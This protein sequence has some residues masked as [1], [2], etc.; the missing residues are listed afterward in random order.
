MTKTRIQKLKWAVVALFI[1]FCAVALGFSTAFRNSMPAYAASGQSFLNRPQN[2]WSSVNKG[3]IF[4]GSDSDSYV[5]TD[6]GESWYNFTKCDNE[7]SCWNDGTL[8]NSSNSTSYAAATG[9]YL[10]MNSYASAPSGNI[11][12]ASALNFQW[13]TNSDLNF[14]STYPYGVQYNKNGTQHWNY[15]L[16][17]VPIQLG[18]DA[19]K[20]I[21]SGAISS[22]G[23][24]V[25][26]S[27]LHTDAWQTIVRMNAFMAFASPNQGKSI[28]SKLT[29]W[30]SKYQTNQYAYGHNGTANTTVSVSFDMTLD[31]G[32]YPSTEPDI[33][34][35]GVFVSVQFSHGASFGAT[36]RI[37]ITGLEIDNF[38]V[39]PSNKGL[40]SNAHNPSSPDG[41]WS[42]GAKANFKMDSG[43]WQAGSS[44]SAKTLSTSVQSLRVDT[45]TITDNSTVTAPDG[46]F[47]MGYALNFVPGAPIFVYRK[48]MLISTD[49]YADMNINDFR[50]CDPSNIWFDVAYGSVSLSA[51]ST[52]KYTGREIV[53]TVN[54]NTT[55]K[56]NTFQFKS[57]YFR[58]DIE[59]KNRDTGATLSGAPIEVGK[60][61][62]QV[63]VY[64]TSD[65][66]NEGMI[67]WGKIYNNNLKHFKGENDTSVAL[68]KSTWCNFEITKRDVSV[69]VTENDFIFTGGDLKPL[70]S[71]TEDKSKNNSSDP[72]PDLADATVTGNGAQR[73]VTED[74]NG[75]YWYTLTL[76]STSYYK[77]ASYNTADVITDD[78]NTLRIRFR[79]KRYYLDWNVSGGGNST[80]N[81]ATQNAPFSVD[82][83]PKIS[84]TDVSVDS[85]GDL[86]AKN[87]GSYTANYTLTGED[88]DNYT[89]SAGAAAPT[90]ANVDTVSKNWQIVPASITVVPELRLTYNAAAQTPAFTSAGWQGADSQNVLLNTDALQAKTDHA[91]GGY[92]VTFTLESGKNYIFDNHTYSYTFTW[93]I[94]K[95]PLTFTAKSFSNTYGDPVPELQ[96]GTTGWNH[97]N[98]YTVEGYK[99]ADNG[100]GFNSIIRLVYQAGVGRYSD[101]GAYDVTVSEDESQITDAAN[102]EKV[103]RNYNIAFIDGVYT[104]TPRTVSYTVDGQTVD[105]GNPVALTGSSSDAVLNRDLTENNVTIALFHN[106]GTSTGG[107]LKAGDHYQ[108]TATLGG[109]GAGNY[110]FVAA[111]AALKINKITVK[112]ALH[113]FSVTYGDTI[114]FVGQWEKLEGDFLP[115][116][117]AEVLP[118]LSRQSNKPTATGHDA[119][120]DFSGDDAANYNAEGVYDLQGGL[121]KNYAIVTVNKRTV[122]YRFNSDDG[123]ITG[124]YGETYRMVGGAWTANGTT[125]TGY[126]ADGYAMAYDDDVSLITDYLKLNHSAIGGC[127]FSASASGHLAVGTYTLAVELVASSEANQNYNVLFDGVRL[128]VT[129][130][131]ITVHIGDMSMA[132]GDFYPKN[133]D[134]ALDGTLAEGDRLKDLWDFAIVDGEGNKI[135]T[136]MKETERFGREEFITATPGDYAIRTVK[137]TNDLANNYIIDAGTMTQTFTVTKRSVAISIGS[138]GGSFGT[139][140][141]TE[142]GVNRALA[143]CINVIDPMD[144]VFPEFEAG[145]MPF[146]VDS[147][148]LTG[149]TIYEWGGNKY[150]A[151]GSYSLPIN[152]SDEYKDKYQIKDNTAGALQ[153]GKGTYNMDGV[154]FEDGTFEYDGDP[155]R[156]QIKGTLPTGVDGITVGIS[157]S[158]FPV[159]HVSDGITTVTATF[160]T[161][162]TNYSV[163][164]QRTAQ[165]Q[166]SPRSIAVKANDQK[167]EYCGNESNLRFN[168]Y[169]Y[170]VTSGTLVAGDSLGLVLVK[171]AGWECG[172]YPISFTDDNGNPDYEIT[173]KNGTFTVEPRN[174]ENASIQVSGIDPD[175]YTYTG[176]AVNLTGVAIADR[177]VAGIQGLSSGKDYF[178]S[179]LDNTNVVRDPDGNIQ[180]AAQF[181]VS[182]I[183]NYR[184]SFAV[185][186]KIIPKEISRDIF[187]GSIPTMTYNGNPQTPGSFEVKDT[188]RNAK[189]SAA[190]DYSVS[191]ENITDA[192]EAAQV[193]LTGKGNYTG[194]YTVYY[195]I[196]PCHVGSL[197]IAPIAEQEYNRNQ[198]FP[199]PTVTL[200]SVALTVDR[201]FTFSYGANTNVGEGSVTVTGRGNFTGS[202]EVNFNI[203]PKGLLVDQSNVKD[204]VYSGNPRD[205]SV[206]FEG[207]IQGDPA[208]KARVTYYTELRV[209]L[210]GTPVDVGSYIASVQLEDGVINYTIQKTEVEFKITPYEVKANWTIPKS[211]I[212]NGTFRTV[213]C[214]ANMG[215]TDIKIKADIAIV[216]YDSNGGV[217]DAP[218]NAGVYRAVAELDPRSATSKNF[219]LKENDEEFPTAQELRIEKATLNVTPGLYKKSFGDADGIYTANVHGLGDDGELQVAFSRSVSFSKNDWDPEN[220]LDWRDYEQTSATPYL[221]D[222]VEFT[223]VNC[224]NNYTLVLLQGEGSGLRIDA[225]VIDKVAP[226]WE[227]F[228]G[229]ADP[230]F[231]EEWD[232]GY[233]GIKAKITYTRATGND[234]GSYS[235]LSFQLTEDSDFRN[236]RDYAN[237]IVNFAR[238]GARNKF[239]I[240]PV[241]I[242]Y[243]IK[244]VTKTFGQ[245]DD[246]SKYEWEQIVEEGVETPSLTVTVHRD[247]GESAI[248]TGYLI[249]LALSNPNYVAKINRSEPG[250]GGRL[251]VEPLRIETEDNIETERLY[252]GTDI[253]TASSD[254]NNIPEA[255]RVSANF[256]VIAT[257]SQSS[258][259]EGIDISVRYE[260]NDRVS[261]N[262][263]L[264]EARVLVGEG[265]IMPRTIKVWIDD[266][267]MEYGEEIPEISLRYDNLIAGDRSDSVISR[268]PSPAFGE[269][270]VNANVGTY[271]IT[272]NNDGQSTNYIFDVTDTATVTVKRAPISVTVNEE[273]GTFVQTVNGD[274]NVELDTDWFLFDGLKHGDGAPVLYK[275]AFDSV[276]PGN[277]VIIVEFSERE[278]G[279]Y[280]LMNRFVSVPAYLKPLPVITFDNVRTVYNGEAVGVNPS[281]TVIQPATGTILTVGYAVRYVGDNYDSREA[282]VGAGTYTVYV[283]SADGYY[284]TVRAEGSLQI[285][286]AAVRIII[287]GNMKQTYGEFAELS[288]VA[289]GTDK[290]FKLTVKYPF[291][292]AERPEAGTHTVEAVFDGDANYLPNAATAELKIEPRALRVNF[293]DFSNLVYNGQPQ[294]ITATFTGV[295]EGDTCEP[296]IIYSSGTVPKDA[297]TY[298][299]TVT[300]SD[301]SY[302]VSGNMMQ[303]YTIQKRQLTITANGGTVNAGEKPDTTLIFD[304][305]VQGEGVGDIKDLPNVS[306][307]GVTV[308]EN[309]IHL[310][311]GDDENYD[312][313]LESGTFTVVYEKTTADKSSGTVIWI[314][315][316]CVLG[317]ALLITIIALIARRKQEN[318]YTKERSRRI[319]W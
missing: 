136:V 260:V 89:F 79:I 114:S 137:S 66:E 230:D 187:V 283:E 212:Y 142:A 236:E 156:P 100:L 243:K 267:T 38:K 285:D 81:G 257:F 185:N 78:E 146:A 112:V 90:E 272:L 254:R 29:D 47:F 269:F 99:G 62:A 134:A 179:Y 107:Y 278:N 77:F 87:V 261:A 287:G 52:Y 227:K 183:G 128:T 138:L 178:V 167:S 153:I 271:V 176:K 206:T 149:V 233:F 231:I 12:T 313:V 32:G 308:G 139:E 301:S 302:T 175:G 199:T 42:D 294:P 242:E 8:R 28:T 36:R 247:E 229:Q 319:G 164:A 244:D 195:T 239:T 60:Y 270:G 9:K 37:E 141:A 307:S 97:R 118:H 155:H 53:P 132:Y 123:V 310:S 170:S 190:D 11:S 191:Y 314:V 181:I 145:E 163:P 293:S 305:F 54:L 196:L 50:M 160:M 5:N 110:N 39:N 65:K 237:F 56:N 48:E 85:S 15:F 226:T 173:K 94:D 133:L 232:S 151:V 219:T 44:A 315:L 281:V 135:A 296:I 106:A 280:Y 16:Y 158:G 21:R 312:F 120:V 125:L 108:I 63:T 46:Y 115:G 103:H 311:G 116:D 274:K 91:D 126:L 255:Y 221:F 59:Y 265:K 127:G 186:F 35:V 70:Y 93:F 3:N 1:G 161:A 204:I 148:N 263:I 124:V 49:S 51:S 290:E 228:Y 19:R 249:N 73:N 275:A 246:T 168:A 92:E 297:G 129:P 289:R 222:T 198:I 4:G 279:N 27:N 200:N 264:P 286:K 268:E 235:F 102:I 207:V 68:G 64:Y 252:N 259:G 180:S 75:Y 76:T 266:F 143:T 150:F 30:D 251:Y 101:V 306:I 253:V 57:S 154:T 208:P 317:V 113:D 61:Q 234:V 67:T 220:P 318:E 284:D 84:G 224:D 203:V 211:M 194:T 104:V 71:K 223:S 182:G 273:K 72:T 7:G 171:T 117:D 69:T 201:D 74:N 23:A 166:I 210:D 174:I 159:T 304:G 24:R 33:L 45:D 40:Y 215:L 214:D 20:Q 130:R 169:D 98:G 131:P 193:I 192:S 316:S 291:G 109:D 245:E 277:T 217:I 205:L 218:R 282:P 10:T 162:S 256:R 43:G 288:A 241:H 140:G 165:A 26:F 202:R 86:S 152:V 300:P 122:A 18:S 13:A 189:L 6:D 184:G 83:L 111:P 17:Y 238:D 309:S 2:G 295:L 172:T 157:Y 225:R 96:G 213:R 292:T 188:G 197:V 31:S 216:Y 119:S 262:Y 144:A 82:N 250:W 248:S 14:G 41:G 22:F 240:K 58:Y 299:A 80:Y 121:T 95:A 105:Y 177:G 147:S 209:K 34:V 88:A 25:S 258:V 276:E 298:H 55:A 303:V